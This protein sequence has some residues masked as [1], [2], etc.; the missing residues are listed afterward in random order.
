MRNNENDCFESQG[1]DHH[2]P[3]ALRDCRDR[4]R[5]LGSGGT[6]L[7]SCSAHPG[8]QRVPGMWI[9]EVAWRGCGTLRWQY[10]HWP[11]SFQLILCCRYFHFT[12]VCCA[13]LTLKSAQPKRYF[14]YCRVSRWDVSMFP[15]MVRNLE[16]RKFGQNPSHPTQFVQGAESQ[17]PDA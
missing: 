16:N 14:L 4:D 7:R 11:D 1:Y 9:C 17:R 6:L 5:P 10:P 2:I 12:P 15:V 3:P 13:D 8:H